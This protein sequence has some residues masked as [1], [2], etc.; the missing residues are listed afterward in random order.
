MGKVLLLITAFFL[1]FSNHIDAKRLMLEAE[2]VDLTCNGSKEVRNKDGTRVDCLYDNTAV[3]YD[4]ANKWGECIGQSLHY[5]RMTN[6]SP[7]CILIVEQVKDCKYVERALG[8][9]VRVA[10]IDFFNLCNRGTEWLRV[11]PKEVKRK[12]GSTISL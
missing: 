10:T 8:L 6:T 12:L 7:M 2:Y 4:F 11:K 3:E 9:G 5:A 1:L